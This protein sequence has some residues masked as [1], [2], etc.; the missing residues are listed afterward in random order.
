MRDH[1]AKR[2]LGIIS[3]IFLVVSCA[4]K[5][6]DDSAEETGVAFTS[7]DIVVSNAGSDAVL[8]FDSAGKFKRVLVSLDTTAGEAVTGIVLNKV[9]RQILVA[10]DGVD[11]VLAVN[12]DDGEVSSF[13][14]NANLTGTIRGIT[15][16][17]NG[18]ILVVETSNI[19]RFSSVGARRVTDVTDGSGTWPKALQTT[20]SEVSARADG[21]FVHCSTGADVVRTYG[22]DAVQVASVA[23]GIAATTDVSSCVSAPSDAA[24]YAMFSGTTD[25]LRKL[26]PV[27]LATTWSYSNLTILSTPTG[28]G[29]RSNG[30]ILALDSVFNHVVEVSAAGTLVGILEGND[31]DIDD[32]LSSPQFIYVIP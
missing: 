9:T 16:L 8:L 24:V 5:P 28:L 6:S 20:G 21:G 30:N 31:V 11:R 25:T 12:Q 14:I 4:K 29:V 15:Q 18:D 26:D 13:I 32:M 2:L 7:G 1:S 17:V 27:T 10:V 19:E 22:A 23:S 3:L